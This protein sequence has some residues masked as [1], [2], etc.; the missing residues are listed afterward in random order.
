VQVCLVYA[1]L[2][3]F[4]ICVGVEQQDRV[5]FLCSILWV[6][7]I[8]IPI[9]FTLIYFPSTVHKCSFR[10]SQ[11]SWLHFLL[12]FLMTANLTGVRLNLNVLICISPWLKMLI[13]SSCIYW[14]FI[15][16]LRIVYSV[17]LPIYSLDYL[18]FGYLTLRVIYILWI[19]M[20][21]CHIDIV[22]W[23]FGKDFL[24]SCRMC[25][26]SGIVSFTVQRVF[27]L[28][29]SHLLIPAFIS[30]AIQVLFENC[31]LHLYL[32]VFALYFPQS[33]KS[34]IQVFGP[35]W[36]DFCT[37]WEIG[38]KFQFSIYEHPAF[39]ASFVKE[40]F[41]KVYFCTLVENQIAVPMWGYFWVLYSIPLVHMSV[42]V[43]IACCFGPFGSVI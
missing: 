29:Q 26:Y 33:F 23:L 1:H 10:R 24:L 32:Q 28:M 5:A 19:S 3:S 9:A 12:V 2:H 37:G 39:Q 4:G 20:Y 16:L 31:C 43:S 35:F 42:F 18:F 41:S 30:R 14:L 11:P 6:T 13:I 36:V 27:N 22:R 8:L 15:L 21:Q 7:S 40:T 38:I 17:C 34:Y 25:V